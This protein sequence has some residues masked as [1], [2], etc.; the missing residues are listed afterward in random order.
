[1]LISQVSGNTLALRSPRCCRSLAPLPLVAA[2]A[3]VGTLRS[4]SGQYDWAPFVYAIL[5]FLASLGRLGASVCPYALPAILNIWDAASELRTQVIS[6]F[7]F[8]GVEPVTTGLRR[9]SAT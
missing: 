5:L 6:F 4:L 8:A 1:V 7:A 9:T 2:A 3:W